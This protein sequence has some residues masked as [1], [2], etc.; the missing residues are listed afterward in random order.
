MRIPRLYFKDALE[1]GSVIQLDNGSTHYLSKVL[2]LRVKSQIKLFN[3]NEGEFLATII[4]KSSTNATVSI[5]SQ[6]RETE[7]GDSK[8]HVALAMTKG[9][10]MDYAIQKSIELG[11]ASIT[12]FFSELSEVKI[13]DQNRLENKLRH[14]K[15]VAMNACQQCGR[16]SLPNIETPKTFQ[17]F[18]KQKSNDTYV[19]L[20]ASS[21]KK[22]KEISFTNRVYLVFGPEGGFSNSELVTAN[23]KI[24]VASLGPRILRSE[25]APVVALS[26]LQSE[27]GDL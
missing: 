23:E 22:L 3:N 15:S 6:I 2:R 17:D 13:K 25:T 21:H 27:F 14:W 5:D 19:L 8:F 7:F 9:E 26:I 18:I 16:L 20:D 4:S 10:R 24:H 1:R 11:V 12:P